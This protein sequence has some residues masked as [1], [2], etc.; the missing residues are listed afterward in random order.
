MLKGLL[1]PDPI[2]HSWKPAKRNRQHLALLLAS[3]VAVLEWISYFYGTR[4]PTRE[5]YRSVS[6]QASN[7]LRGEELRHVR[8][9]KYRSV[10][11]LTACIHHTCP[12]KVEMRLPIVSLTISTY[13]RFE[14]LLY[15]LDHYGNAN[16]PNLDAIFIAWVR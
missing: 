16:M 7:L 14:H 4:S 3:A 15:T 11:H 5:V 6:D 2:V 10:C 9:E 12:T 8:E 1:E 13:T